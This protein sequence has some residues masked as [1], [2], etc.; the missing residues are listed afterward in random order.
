MEGEFSMDIAQVN[1]FSH[2]L[3]ISMGPLGE[4]DIEAELMYKTISIY[5]HALHY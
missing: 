5:T 4:Y 3:R 2:P 1:F